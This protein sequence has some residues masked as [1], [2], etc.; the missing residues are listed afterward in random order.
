M[1]YYV[2]RRTIDMA[3]RL[4]VCRHGEF[5]AGAGDDGLDMKYGV[6]FIVLDLTCA[7][8]LMRGVGVI[9]SAHVL[10]SFQ[11]SDGVSPTCV[12][13][14]QIEVL[15]PEVVPW[16]RLLVAYHGLSSL[17]SQLAQMIKVLDI[18]VFSH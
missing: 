12:F 1:E 11:A 10:R 7:L 6:T 2:G 14:F 18:S 9:S 13:S 17:I 15:S 16:L 5:Q 8:D 3:Y 4:F